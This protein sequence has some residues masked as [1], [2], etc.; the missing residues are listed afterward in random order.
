MTKPGSISLGDSEQHSHGAMGS[1]TK[2][3]AVETAVERQGKTI[4]DQKLLLLNK[5]TTGK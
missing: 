5:R 1:I 3:T 2:G 4:K